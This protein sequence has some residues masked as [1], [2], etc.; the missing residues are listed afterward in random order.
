MTTSHFRLFLIFTFCGIAAAGALWFPGTP[1]IDRAIAAEVE[2]PSGNSWTI[3]SP[4]PALD[5]EH[6][7]QDGNGFFQPVT[8][9]E[10]GK[11]YVV[12]FWATWCGPCISSMPHLAALQQQYRGRGVQIVSVSDEPLKTVTTFLE[13][14]AEMAEGET[15][16]FADITAAYSLTTDPDRSVYEAYMDAS[17]QQGIPTAFIVGKDSKVEWIGHPMEMDG[18]LEQVVTD[19]WNRVEFA[20]MYQAERKFNDDLQKISVLAGSGKFEEA[21]VV[22]DGEIKNDVPQEIRDRWIAIRERVKL[23]AGM[24]DQGVVDFFKQELAKN[25]GDAVGVARN[26]WTLYQA[27]R[28]VKGLDELLTASIEALKGEVAATD[29]QSKP[30][31]LDTLAHLY[32][33]TG[34][35]DSA[36]ETQQTAVDATEGRTQQRLARYLDELKEKKAGPAAEEKKEAAK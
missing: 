31:V 25:K 33:A 11:V 21:L 24:I 8:K 18:P 16:T 5:I 6:W 19:S 27:S 4:A 15:K 28:E 36:I 12:E 32:E 34:D 1:E 35:L 9:F 3:G 20:T 7:I 17:E 30:V 2:Q 29:E 14:E 13:R 26:A 23:S 10:E 22:I